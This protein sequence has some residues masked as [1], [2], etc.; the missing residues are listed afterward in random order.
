MC[1]CDDYPIHPDEQGDGS[2]DVSPMR[3]DLYRAAVTKLARDLAEDDRTRAEAAFAADLAASP[4]TEPMPIAG[5]QG[6]TPITPLTAAGV[7]RALRDAGIP[8]TMPTGRGGRITHR[9]R[10]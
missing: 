8:F 2:P 9:E 7:Q 10:H 4:L 6:H 5:T 3:D 1:R